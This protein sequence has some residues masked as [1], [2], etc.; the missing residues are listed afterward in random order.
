MFTSDFRY[1]LH[2][3]RKLLEKLK[4]D[5][6]QSREKW[7]KVRQKN[8]HSQTQWENLR[9]EFS[10]RKQD[11]TTSATDSGFSEMVS[12]PSTSQAF[13]SEEPGMSNFHDI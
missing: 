3:K 9:D 10:R 8:S 7:L 11:S 4:I 2:E 12:I 1:E 13:D 5:L 6:Y